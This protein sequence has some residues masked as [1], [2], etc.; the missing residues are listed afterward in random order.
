MNISSGTRTFSSQINETPSSL[1]YSYNGTDISQYFIASYFESSSDNFS[2]NQVPTWCTKIRVIL[3]GAGGSGSN[4]TKIPEN[5]NAGNYVNQN[6]F[7]LN[8]Y[9]NVTVQS[10]RFDWDRGRYYIDTVTTQ[11]F[12]LN[13]G[14]PR[15]IDTHINTRQQQVYENKNRTG[16]GY[17]DS[18]AD[19][20]MLRLQ[21]TYIN[22]QAYTVRNG[23]YGNG[24]YR[25]VHGYYNRQFNNQ[26][27]PENHQNN[28]PNTQ[29]TPG[30]NGAVGGGG[31]FIYIPDTNIQNKTVNIQVG[32][33][34]AAST[35]LQIQ[36][37]VATA[38]GGT[39]A[40]STTA[41]TAGTV[42]TILPGTTQSSGSGA[43][44]G[45]NG[46]TQYVS[47]GIT[48]QKGGGGAAGSRA[49]GGQ[50]SQNP[51]PGASGQQGY[52]RIYFLT[53]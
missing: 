33:T 7:N 31:A 3:V 39:N 50:S 53:E 28:A 48:L 42:Q 26:N 4:G 17:N 10:D 30:Q 21:L 2:N 41:G 25:N 8:E 43:T 35:V 45:L 49:A 51:T 20:L 13:A 29:Q 1:G 5:T 6:A 37:T 40:V 47:S 12:K 15:P 23:I 18:T 46:S 14:T 52:Y 34:S 44:S 9:T 16:Q 24:K 19:E 11:E 32:S 36:T 27:L 22:K 38:K